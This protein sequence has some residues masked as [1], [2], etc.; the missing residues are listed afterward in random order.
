MQNTI[1]MI[2]LAGAITLAFAFSGNAFAAEEQIVKI[3]HVGQENFRAKDMGLVHRCQVQQVVDSLQHLFGLTDD[4]EV[5][6]LGNL[7]GE[8]R[9]AV[10]NGHF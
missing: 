6:V 3:G 1:R 5:G 10:V 9:H 4:V 7:P 2:P 8:V